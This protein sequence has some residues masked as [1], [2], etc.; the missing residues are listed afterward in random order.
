M[1]VNAIFQH[2]C[3]THPGSWFST[4]ASFQSGHAYSETCVS[5]KMNKQLYIS[6]SIGL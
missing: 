1:F 4:F 2:I 5:K 3:K 6:T